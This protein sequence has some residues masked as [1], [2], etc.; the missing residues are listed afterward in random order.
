MATALPV[1]PLTFPADVWV[2]PSATHSQWFSRIDWYLNW[3]LSKGLAHEP[4]RLSLDLLR[5]MDENGIAIQSP[6]QGGPMPLMVIS[7]GR[8]P[9][10]KCVVL[11]SPVE[12]APWLQAVHALLSGLGPTKAQIF[13]P[14]GSD[15]LA[16]RALW[17]GFSPLQS[18]IEFSTD[19][20]SK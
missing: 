1:N 19:E 14:S 11:E 10:A 15:P 4:T 7:Q 3:Q 9:A 16:A 2:L 13:L 6:V 12:I 17:N 20:E 18:E 5:I 8:I